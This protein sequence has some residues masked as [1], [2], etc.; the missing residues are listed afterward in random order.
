MAHLALAWIAKKPSTSTVI[1]GASRPEQVLDNLKAL[2]VI[3]KLTPDIE[4]KIEAILG[5]RPDPDVS[6]RVCAC[7]NVR[8]R[9]HRGV[10]PGDVRKARVG[11]AVEDALLRWFRRF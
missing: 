3:P 2:D 6:S 4:E 10:C 7:R 9:T 8:G 1:L 5:N 11:Q